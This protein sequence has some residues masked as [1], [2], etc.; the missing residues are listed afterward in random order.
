MF[1]QQQKEGL[2]E[3]QK[4]MTEAQVQPQCTALE[5]CTWDGQPAVASVNGRTGNNQAAVFCE[6]KGI[7]VQVG[8]AKLS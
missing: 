5:A 7:S 2:V 1:G 6:V 3:K 4:H 8:K